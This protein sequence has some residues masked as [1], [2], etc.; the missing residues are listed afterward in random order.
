MRAD[1]AML[2]ACLAFLA[3]V[4]S[5]ASALGE[6]PKADVASLSWLA[7]AWGGDDGGTFNEEH[8]ISPKAGS[9]LA[10][11]RDVKNGKTVGFE[12]LRIEEQGDSLV[13]F[14]SP[15]GR[16]PTPFKLVESGAKRAV[17]ENGTLEFPRRVLYFRDGETLHARI[18][19]T[20]GGKP[21]SK[22]WT[23]RR[24]HE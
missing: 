21:A 22:E 2:P 24:T 13:Y 11:H 16:P 19:G 17:F 6:G 4:V 5:A 18:E 14:A 20:R 9:M 15:E 23:W 7:G 8:W 12:F 3:V 1:F 10:V